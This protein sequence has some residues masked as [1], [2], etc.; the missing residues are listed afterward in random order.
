MW[1]CSPAA[2]WG[3]KSRAQWVR[4]KPRT[5]WSRVRRS[6]KPTESTSLLPKDD[7]SLGRHKLRPSEGSTLNGCDDIIPAASVWTVFQAQWQCC[8][9]GHRSEWSLSRYRRHATALKP[10]TYSSWWTSAG[11]GRC[12]LGRLEDRALRL[13]KPA[14]RKR[15]T[16][17]P[18]PRP[19]TTA[20]LNTKQH[21][22]LR[23]VR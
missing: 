3:L 8:P 18:R 10:P 20:H 21:V 16:P 1:K 23:P 15:Q 12:L 5:S 4:L 17:R 9:S 13:P 2:C 14:S 6:G 19:R 11:A 22:Q 7:R